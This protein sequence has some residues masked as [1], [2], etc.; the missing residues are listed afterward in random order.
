[1]TDTLTAAIPHLREWIATLLEFSVADA[2][3]Q[4]RQIQYKWIRLMKLG[5]SVQ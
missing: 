5:G 4:F 2:L 1:M 3:D